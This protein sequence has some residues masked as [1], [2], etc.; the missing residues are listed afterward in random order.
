MSEKSITKGKH[1]TIY[2]RTYIE[3]ALNAGHTLREMALHLGKDPAT[4]SK[5]IKRN[6]VFKESEFKLKG[7]CI[8][9]KTC[10]KKNL[11]N[12]DCNRLCKKC[13]TRNCYRFC[14][15][16]KIKT[17]GQVKKF[18]HVCNSCETKTTCKLNKYKYSAKVADAKYQDQLTTSRS[19]INITKSELE[20][21]DNLVSPL[22]KK[23]QP[24]NHI[25]ANHNE[26]IKCSER[27]LYN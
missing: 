9:R 5:E 3:D 20:A 24:V 1:L 22:I 18:P 8:S 12:K 26:E 19:G 27:T 17:C 6:R 7:G 21:L 15:D 10:Q 4:I 14:P 16:F 25:Y 23:G 13:T 11:C 2:D